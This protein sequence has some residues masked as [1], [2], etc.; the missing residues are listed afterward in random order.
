MNKIVKT[1]LIVA[2]VAAVL[3]GLHL[4]VNNGGGLLEA[5]KKIHGQG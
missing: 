1:I 5:L 3:A 4:L 2:V